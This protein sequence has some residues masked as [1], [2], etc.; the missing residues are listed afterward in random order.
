M[1][2]SQSLT[3]DTPL[4]QNSAATGVFMNGT[5]DQQRMAVMTDL[6][7]IPEV[8]VDF[9]LDHIVPNSGVNLERTM[10]NL[11]RKGILLDAGWNLFIDALP[12]NSKDN[13]QKVFLKM[14]AIYRNIITSTKFEVGHSR[15]PTLDFGTCPD[16]API[17]ETNIRSRPDGCGQL[18]S[19]HSTHTSQCGYPSEVKGEYHWFNIAYVEEYKKRNTK[20]DLN[21]NVLKILWSLHHMMNVDRRRRFA[22]GVTIENTDTRIWFCCRQIVF[23][24]HRFDF[25]KE[26]AKLIRL[27]TSLAYAD[28]VK[29][30]Y[31]PTMELFWKNDR[32]NYLITIQGKDNHGNLVTKVYETIDIIA[33]MSSNLRGRATRVYEAFDVGNPGSKVVIKDSWVDVNRPKEADTLSEIL[34]GA[35]E[36]EKAMFL[37]V[38]LHGVVII[39]GRQDLT[40]N[41]VD[42]YLISAKSS[43]KQKKVPDML[44]ELA[45]MMLDA[46]IAD[47]GIKDTV[48]SDRIHKA[49]I[50]EPLKALQPDSQSITLITSPDVSALNPDHGAKVPPRV[51]GPKAH[52]RIV[53]KE[54]GMSLHSLSRLRQ[55][56]LPVVIQAM[57]DVLKVLAFL[58]KKGYVHRDISP[59]NIIIYN[60]RAK[61]NDLEFAK[62]YGSGTSN[63]I[64]TGTYNFMAVEVEISAYLYHYGPSFSHNPLHD[65]ESL[66]WVGLWFL[67]CHYTAG[68]LRSVTVQKHIEVVKQIGETLFNN[69]A[70]HR[71]RRNALSYSTLITNSNPLRFPKSVQYLLVVLE[72]FRAQLVTYYEDYNPKQPQNRSFFTPDVH[73]K[74]GVLFENVLESLRNDN[75]ELWP[76]DHITTQVTYLKDKGK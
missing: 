8:T 17:S 74:C 10:H 15:F 48:Q 13:E 11:K 76:M 47:R 34:D 60:G 70:D 9:M 49:S 20:K 1:S 66:L 39:D 75:T 4:K 61:L 52:Y 46:D 24:T 18:N 32:W 65:I 41:L 44:D 3:G 69:G 38:L 33:D 7:N 23:V 68:N 36:D 35:S 16:I 53:F 30:G 19:S 40:Q 28:V 56:K 27:I 21:D 6:G 57:H 58:T 25:M 31:D 62:E 59:G 12:K 29:L 71:S 55:I 22:F 67:L 45:E 37:T 50:F 2:Q 26:P 54:R 73:G 42:G 64:R 63:N 51:Y 43:K 14:Q 5:L 72:K